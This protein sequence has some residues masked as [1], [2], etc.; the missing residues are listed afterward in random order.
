[1]LIAR[2]KV[3]E[4]LRASDRTMVA[5]K[6]NNALKLSETV[7]EALHYVFDPAARSDAFL[8]PPQAVADACSDL[9]VHEIALVAGMRAALVGA[10]KLFAP[11]V[12]E[13]K[14]EKDGGKSLLANKKAQLWDKFVAYYE[15]TEREAEDNFDRIFGAAFLRA[16]Q[17]QI[18][19]LRR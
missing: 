10:V 13:Q 4:E 19:R 14:L 5:S 6:E 11:A 17:E 1:M 18:R 15:D 12:I 16:Y 7:E 9:Q 3:K 8:P 2:A